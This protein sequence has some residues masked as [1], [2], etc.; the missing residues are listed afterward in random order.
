MVFDQYFLY[1]FLY[2]MIGYVCEVLYCSIPLKRFVNRGFLHGP[3]LPIYGFGALIVVVS[4]S[5]FNTH[6]IV[7]FL[8]A[9]ALTSALEYVTSYLLEKIFNTK[10]WDYSKHFA[11]INGRVCLLNAS[12]FGLMG[13]V[14]TYWVHPA[15][16]RFVS[17]V[18]D[19]VLHPLSSGLLFIISVDA[20]SSIFRMAAFQKQLAEFRLRTKELEERIEVLA[21]QGG[22]PSLDRLRTRIDLER[23]ELKARLNKQS[24]HFLNAFPSITSK[25]QEQR[26]Q[27]ELLK[28]NLRDYRSKMQEQRQRLHK[29]AKELKNRGK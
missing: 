20:T 12:L 17:H 5:F 16:T 13:L 4:L 18:P 24:R 15:L 26:V 27:L 8:V 11:N 7:V 23:E 10:L 3:Y 22:T 9:M 21:K 28:M 25:S 2:A 14:A 1:F 29:A 6:P 19:G